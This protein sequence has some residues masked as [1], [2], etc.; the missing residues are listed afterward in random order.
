MVRDEH[1]RSENIFVYAMVYEVQL[2]G[3]SENNCYFRK[4]MFT[5]QTSSTLLRNRGEEMSLQLSRMFG[6]QKCISFFNRLRDLH[7][8]LL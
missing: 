6:R 5:Y 1:E 2:F 3:G 8:L 4:H 7:I